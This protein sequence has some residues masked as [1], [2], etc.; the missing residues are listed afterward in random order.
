MSVF[1]ACCVT[2]RVCVCVCSTEKL[3]G[4]SLAVPEVTQS[5][6]AQKQKLKV[7][8]GSINQVRSTAKRMVNYQYRLV[9]ADC[10]HM[11]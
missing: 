1:T 8:L 6:V 2:E 5:E 4:V 3:S 7:V 10:R 9:I 11:A